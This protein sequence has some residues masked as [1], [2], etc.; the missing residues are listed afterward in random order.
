MLN[1]KKKMFNIHSD[2]TFLPER[3]KTEKCKKL[4]CNKESYIV[5]IRALKQTLNHRLIIKKK[6]RSNSI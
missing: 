1:I 4:V 2:L 5:L 6:T 3:K